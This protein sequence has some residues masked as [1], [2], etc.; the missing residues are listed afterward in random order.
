MKDTATVPYNDRYFR[1]VLSLLA[2]HIIVLYNDKDSFF[3][4]VFTF[5]YLRGMAG[6]FVIALLLTEYV[7]YITVRLDWKF[8]WHANTLLR[9]F[10]QALLAFVAPSLLAFL[11]AAFLFWI[12]NINIFHTTYLQQDYTVIV[13]MILSIN[14]YYFGLNSFLRLRHTSASPNPQA[15]YTI[16]A[17]AG[18]FPIEKKR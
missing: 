9:L 7:H 8:D 6:S 14:M 13:F 1:I 15:T 4:A 2:A 16:P 17:P 10:W 3:Q 5:S 12:F 18:E 11:L